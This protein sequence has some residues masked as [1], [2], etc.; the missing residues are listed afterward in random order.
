MSELR[1]FDY[2]NQ[3]LRQQNKKNIEDVKELA[4]EILTGSPL[5]GERKKLIT[6]I[7]NHIS[8]FD[9]E[10]DVNTALS[11][12]IAN[13]FSA[14]HFAKP[15]SKQNMS[16]TLQKKFLSEK[17]VN[18]DK[19]PGCGPQAIR[20]MDGNLIKGDDRGGKATKSMDFLGEKGE[21]IFAKV[22]VGVGGGQDNQYRDVLD[23]LKEAQKYDTAH[24]DK[25]FV[26]LVDGDYYTHKK[27]ASLNEY[28]GTNIRITT[29][30]DY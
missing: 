3:G 10:H 4:R 19:L 7:K 22:T 2:Y 15:A 24:G 18:V 26:A 16:E 30:D 8:R 21:Y 23:F 13:D 9:L 6:K 5:K 27:I 17:N 25:Q 29:S 12:I 20:L 1:F 11:I 14:S 28:A